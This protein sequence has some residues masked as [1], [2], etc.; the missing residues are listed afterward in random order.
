MALSWKSGILCMT[1]EGLT[2]FELGS[3]IYNMYNI[4]ERS[5]QEKNPVA[6]LSYPSN[7]HTSPIFDTSRGGA[8]LTWLFLDIE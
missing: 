6:P 7:I 2:L 1:G 4:G 5:E 3:N 8:G